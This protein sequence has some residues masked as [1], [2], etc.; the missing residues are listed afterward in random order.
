MP[1]SLSGSPGRSFC[2]E[3]RDEVIKGFI[4]AGQLPDINETLYQQYRRFMAGCISPL[5]TAAMV[6]GIWDKKQSL[7]D[8]AVAN[9]EI[10]DEFMDDIGI[11]RTVEQGMNRE[12]R[13]LW[14]QRAV[15]FTADEAVK[16]LAAYNAQK[17]AQKEARAARNRQLT[18]EEQEAAAKRRDELLQIARDQAAEL[19]SQKIERREREEMDSYDR[20]NKSLGRKRDW[21][22]ID[23]HQVLKIKP[24]RRGMTRTGGVSH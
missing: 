10:T 17:Q 2:R 14:H 13:V 21:K 11:P 22:K 6:K 20:L 23:V 19:A 7:T 8:F 5:V 3:S 9:G 24:Q 4:V 16:R 12:D 15:L 1:T 18:P